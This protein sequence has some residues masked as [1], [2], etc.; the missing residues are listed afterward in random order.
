MTTRLCYFMPSKH[1]IETL[2]KRH[3]K[4]SR[5][6]DCNDVFEL[7]N[8]RAP[9]TTN[10][11]RNRK[12]RTEI[13]TWSA[14]TNKKMGL[15]CF[16]NHH[17]SPLMW[18]H[19][20]DQNRGAC[21]VFDYEEQLGLKLAKVNYTRNRHESQSSEG[22]NL[23]SL[24]SETPLEDLIIHCATKEL[25]WAY[26]EEQRLLIFFDEA[27]TLVKDVGDLK[28]LNWEGVLTLK[29][30]YLGAKPDCCI[31]AIEEVLAKKD[32]NVKV[33][34]KRAAFRDFRIVEQRDKSRHKACKDSQDCTCPKFNPT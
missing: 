21:L 22:Q 19:Y 20:A 5:F 31:A 32:S 1:L 29:E 25:D 16:S 6:N 17:Y 9:Q 27:K 11:Q 15:I 2:E 30:V 24:T 8:F 34:Q 23:P 14:E 18:A 4:I 13:R 33:C 28:F 3:L 10:T 26:E 12:I 7:G